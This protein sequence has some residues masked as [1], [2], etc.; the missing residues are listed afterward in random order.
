MTIAS[1]TTLYKRLTH[2]V[3]AAAC[4]ILVNFSLLCA[5]EASADSASAG[6]SQAE[7]ILKFSD[8]EFADRYDEL[9][10]ELRC[11]KCQNQNLA[12]SDAPIAQDLK[13]EL[14]RLLEQGSSNDEILDFMTLRYG[15]FVRYR[16]E[17]TL[18]T[19]SL[20]LVP[21]IVFVSGLTIWIARTRSQRAA[22]NSGEVEPVRDGQQNHGS[23]S[24]E[25][26]AE[27]QAKVDALLGA[28]TND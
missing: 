23:V 9:I 14:F 24:P 25:L 18:Y 27:R 13:S 5:L 10:D 16:P 15:E 21:T 2:V 11:P 3:W 6:V 8:P 4:L 19:V 12:D 22:A 1:N 20:W 28:R 17:L 26:V 7:P